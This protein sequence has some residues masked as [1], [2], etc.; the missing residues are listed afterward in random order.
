LISERNIDILKKSFVSIVSPLL[1][2]NYINVYIRDTL[3][4]ASAAAASLEK[5]GEGHK[6]YKT[7]LDNKYKVNMKLLLKEN[8]DL[9]KKYAMNDSLITLIHSLFMSDFVINFGDIRM[10]LTLG[11]ICSKYLKNKWVKDGYKGHQP[12]SEFLLGN[13]HAS[14]TPKG[15]NSIGFAAENENLYLSSFRGG[16]NECFSYGIDRDTKW[17]D[18]DLAS[19]Y[20]TIMSNN[21]EPFYQEFNEDLVVDPSIVSLL[22]DP[23][24]YKASIIYPHSNLSKFNWKNSYSAIKVKFNFP[25]TIKYPPLPVFMDKNITIYPLSGITIVTGHEFLSALNIL[26]KELKLN[27]D[28]DS[29]KYFINI[30][31]GSYIPFKIDGY[32]PFFSAIRELQANRAKYKFLEGH[33]KGSAMERTYKDLGNMIYGKT[34]CGISNKRNYDPRTA[35]MKSMIGGKLSN[36]IL[37][38]YITGFVRALIAELLNTIHVLGGRVSACTTDGFTCDIPDLEEKILKHYRDI[39][40]E[41]S[42]L[43]DYR[44]SRN[45]LTDGKDPR[46]LEIKT[47]TIGLLQ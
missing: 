6:I 19:C 28:L 2:F 3:L 4:L 37:G 17:Y 8:F 36:P 10:P 1:T 24:Y 21:G 22:G 7:P 39:G 43:E 25:E 44:N 31:T 33:G 12:N 40:F 9:F 32:K 46:A 20:A 26:N 5:V 13:T 11:T 41:D 30:I 14:H 38:A 15:I 35:M 16:R 45:I 27:S 34:V 23:D 29:S 47:T 18:Y 42:L